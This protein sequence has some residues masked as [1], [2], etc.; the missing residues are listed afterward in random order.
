MRRR[1]NET[2][3]KQN[4]NNPKESV[5]TTRPNAPPP[6][7]SVHPRLLA[8]RYEH[9]ILT[10]SACKNGSRIRE[11]CSCALAGRVREALPVRGVASIGTGRGKGCLRAV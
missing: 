8:E 9:T 6:H 11:P 2:K 3:I 5:Y 4:R 1:G 7:P 10:R